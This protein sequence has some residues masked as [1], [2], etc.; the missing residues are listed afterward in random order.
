MKCQSRDST[1]QKTAQII[2]KKYIDSAGLHFCIDTAVYS[3]SVSGDAIKM[4][5]RIKRKVT[6][7]CHLSLRKHTNTKCVRV[8]VIRLVAEPQLWVREGRAAFRK[9]VVCV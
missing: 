1:P 6:S 9:E 4:T 2:T 8:E 5:K 3:L 7:Y